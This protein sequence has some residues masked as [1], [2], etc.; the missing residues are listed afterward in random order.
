[1]RNRLPVNRVSFDEQGGGIF[2]ARAGFPDGVAERIADTVKSYGRHRRRDLILEIGAGTGL[3]GQWL[4]RRPYRYL[5]LDNSLPMLDTF[6]SR[7]P[8]GALLAY[9]DAN[10]PWP[11]ADGRARVIFGSRVFQLLDPEH[12][13]D[14]ANRVANPRGAVLIHGKV[15]RKP[16][17]P[18]SV[19]R[20]K[21]HELLTAHGYRPRPAGRVLERLFARAAATGAREVRPVIATSWRRAVRPIDPIDE[22]RQTY[23]MGGITPSAEV[24]ETVLAELKAWVMSTYR[25]PF[26]P[27]LTD[28]SYVLHAAVLPPRRR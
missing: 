20:N 7:L 1:M 3:I 9:A 17:S 27:V 11:V 14:E 16:D 23:S 21:L 5:G 26:A 6:R 10:R 22:W 4:A 15:Q 13:V 12:L 19:L 8:D 2:D 25:D 28:E 24:S 18:K